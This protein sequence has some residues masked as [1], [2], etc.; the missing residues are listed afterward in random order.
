MKRLSYIFLALCILLA[1]V[2]SS[3]C[4][5]NPD[6]AAGDK[7]TIVTAAT[8]QPFEY[9][10]DE[11]QMVGIDIDL[12]NELCKELGLTP[13]FIDT[14]FYTIPEKLESGEADMSL[15]MMTVTDERKKS[16]D[17]SIPYASSHQVVIVK[18][19]NANYIIPTKDELAAELAANKIRL[20]IERGTTGEALLEEYAV[21]ADRIVKYYDM[22]NAVPD[23]LSGKISGIV[24]D[25][26]PAKILCSK[27]PELGVIETDFGYEEYAI[28]FKKGN[29]I[30]RDKVNAVL[31]K[32]IQSG[33][34]DKIVKSYNPA[35]KVVFLVS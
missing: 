30:L 3:A 23:L 7:L 10:N 5:G 6:S 25:S 19:E 32:L 9:Y 11:N 18:K 28:A 20:G 2:F 15:S 29:T 24:Y 33:T 8:I 31:E 26:M 1:A 21:P 13:V 34:V 4:V 22:A 27:N 17:F 12:G 35:F 14:N 16:L